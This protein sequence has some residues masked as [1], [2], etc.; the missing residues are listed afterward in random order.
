MIAVGSE[1]KQMMV[2]NAQQLYTMLQPYDGHG[3][4]LVFE[5]F[6]GEGH[7]SVVHPLISRL[8]RF[9]LQRKQSIADR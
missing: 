4:R 3:L 7:V 9:I 8:L 2:E 5:L 6:E 1:E